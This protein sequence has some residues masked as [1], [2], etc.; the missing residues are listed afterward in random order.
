LFFLVFLLCA[1]Q[2]IN[3]RGSQL[4][5]P[6]SLVFFSFDDGPNAQNATTA[7]L[8]DVLKKYHIQA[9]FCLLGE[10]AEYSPELVRRIYDEGHCI[11][12]HGYA[13]KHAR[14][15]TD[16][17]FRENLFRGEEAISAALGFKMAPLLYRP[18]GGLY[19]SRQEKIFRDAGYTLV[20]V[21][22][23]AYDAAKDCRGRRKV[24]RW[25]IRK[26]KIENG[27]LILLHDER[28]SLSNKEKNLK[29]S[30]QGKFNRSW[31]PDVVDEIIPVLLDKG[32]IF[33]TPDTLLSLLTK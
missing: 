8:L 10:N 7:S 18:H 3:R 24:V 26:L 20:P 6:P 25:L 9:L 32:F 13:D 19:N 5:L 15:M 28:G 23:R 30:S 33:E 11:I 2:T 4:D 14:K 22:V 17:E 1:C 31:I 29:K 12:N 27:G 21:T 16:D